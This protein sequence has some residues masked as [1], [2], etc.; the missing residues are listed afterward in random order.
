MREDGLWRSSGARYK[1]N[2]DEPGSGPRYV[3]VQD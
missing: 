3:A 1:V 2:I